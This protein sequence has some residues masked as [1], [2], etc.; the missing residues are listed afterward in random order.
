MDRH[1]PV[2]AYIGPVGIDRLTAFKFGLVATMMAIPANSWGST[3]LNT[4]LAKRK[5]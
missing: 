3:D 5:N 1:G 4:G 2:Q